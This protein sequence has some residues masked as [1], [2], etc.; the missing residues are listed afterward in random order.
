MIFKRAPGNHRK[1][2]FLIC[3]FL[4]FIINSSYSQSNP[5]YGREIPV[6]ITGL[7]FD[8]ME[9]FI[10]TDGN[11]LFFNSLNSGGNTNLY[12]ASK[13]SDSSFTFKGLVGGIYDPSPDHLDGVA[14]HD[15][16]NN[17]FWVSLRAFPNLHKGKY[18]SGNVTHITKTYGDF[19]ITLPGWIIMD[20]AINY[21]GDRLFYCNAYFGPTFSE[22]IG[23]PCKA[24]LGIASRTNDSTFNKQANSDAMFSNV[25]DTNYI[26]YAPQVTKNGLELHYT[27]IL[28]ATVNSELCLSVRKNITDT[29][30]VPVVLHS[31]NGFVPEA[32]SPDTDNLKMYYHQKK[33]NGLFG[34]F[35][36][37][38]VNYTS[39]KEYGSVP[40]FTL[41]PNPAGNTFTVSFEEAHAATSITIFS[42]EGKEITTCNDCDTVNIADLA[43][44]LYFVKV[45][46]SSNVLFTRLLKE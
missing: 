18:L 17:F 33:E 41:I 19:N 36:R 8:A 2:L 46:I 4:I 22:C 32:A 43:P 10:S 9:P 44:G 30:S 11:T 15:T 29:F 12:Y 13:I 16:A 24:R 31:K 37:Y 25:N 42:I 38:R 35:L 28:K 40:H 21:T 45:Q 27:R 20:A 1:N 6:T 3:A 26:V 5:V 23:I 39:I 34:I 7:T 14:S